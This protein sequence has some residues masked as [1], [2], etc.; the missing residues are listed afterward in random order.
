MQKKRMPAWCDRILARGERLA[1]IT[2]QRGEVT[3]SDH[4]P[5]GFLGL[6]FSLRW[7]S[8]AHPLLFRSIHIFS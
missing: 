8:G 2:Y 5:V 1:Q 6:G 4:K 3:A 7:D